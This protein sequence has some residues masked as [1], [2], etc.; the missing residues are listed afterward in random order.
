MKKNNFRKEF[1]DEFL[2]NIES[3]SNWQKPWNYVSGRPQN[4][5]TG[6]KYN[7]INSIKLKKIENEKGYGDPRWATFKQIQE[8]GYRVKKGSKG[9]TVEYFFAYDKVEKEY[10]SWKDYNE[11]TEEEKEDCSIHSKYFKVFN[12]SQIE[13]IEPYVTFD[14]NIKIDK[15]V[16]TISTALNV[17]IENRNN[18]AT[19]YYSI[20]EDK[21]IMPAAAQFDNAY[22]HNLAALHELSHSTG[23]KKRLNRDMK[24]SFGSEKY[25]YEEL[26]AEFSACFLSEYSKE[27]M[28]EDSFKNH[29]A[30]L[31][32]W[33]DKIKED[34]NYLFNAIKDAEKAADYII[35]E[36]QLDNLLEEV[37]MLETDKEITKLEQEL[38]SE[39]TITKKEKE[40]E[41]MAI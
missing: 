31:K 4:A 20:S 28:T 8:A 1:V 16:D 15:L 2:K 23:A 40:I 9:E 34:D 35:K 19:A 39:L 32:S 18:S 29:A 10:I 38:D 3:V 14:S 27:I 37:K 41:E 36:A 33:T 25:A 7:G 13:G 5:F 30:Y 12:G 17:E 6:R 26:V 11:L 22:A 24:N 21:I